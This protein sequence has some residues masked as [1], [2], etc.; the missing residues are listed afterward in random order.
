MR[1]DTDLI[2]LDDV[3]MKYRLAKQR[4]PSFKEYALHWVRGALVYEDLWALSEVTLR[5]GSGESIGIIGRN[6]A[7]KSTLLKVISRVLVPTAG[8][9][10]VRGRVV[11]VLDLGAG[12]DPELSG[13]EN[14]Y[15]N[16]MFLG[17]TRAEVADACDDIVAASGLG[18]FIASPLRNYSA[19]MAARLAFS[20]ATA[21]VPDVLILDEV[22]AVGDAGFVSRCHQRLQQF[23]DQGATVLVVSHAPQ[24]IRASCRRSIWI[25]GGRVRA[26]GPTDDV[27]GRYTEFVATRRAAIGAPHPTS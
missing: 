12:L 6:G 7:G 23:R 1:A 17:R 3:S 14:I 22:L 16:A 24:E 18:E 27:L 2:R 20:I 8:A 19:G 13:L 9:V 21:W 10:D 25:D 5:I 26:D 4:H 11:P 15:L